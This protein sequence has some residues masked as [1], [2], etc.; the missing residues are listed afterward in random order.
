MTQKYYFHYLYM[1]SFLQILLNYKPSLEKRE[2][3]KAKYLFIL[4]PNLSSFIK[5]QFGFALC[6][7]L[8]RRQRNNIRKRERERGHEIS[9]FSRT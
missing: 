4:I 1:N 6:A 2:H 9:E 5:M 7:Q 8:V 3:K